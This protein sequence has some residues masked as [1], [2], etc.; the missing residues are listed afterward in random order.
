MQV[1]VVNRSHRNHN[2]NRTK[3]TNI[4]KTRHTIQ[5]QQ[6]E[7]DNIVTKLLE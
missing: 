7:K 6:R 4:K 1:Q 5:A 3:E 2:L